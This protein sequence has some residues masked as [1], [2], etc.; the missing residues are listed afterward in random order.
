M[1]RRWWA[2]VS[3]VSPPRSRSTLIASTVTVTSSTSSTTAGFAAARRAVGT[4]L[5]EPSWVERGSDCVLHEL[6]E[7]FGNALGC[8]RC[9]LFLRDPTTTRNSMTHSWLRLPEFAYKRGINNSEW[10]EM[11]PTLLEDDPMFAEALRN[12][13]A[14]YIEDIE[15]APPELL[16]WE[17]EL[18][19]FGHRALIHAPIYLDGEMFGILEP[20]TFGTQTRKW[21]YEDRRLT[22]LVQ[23]KVGPIAADYVRRN[24]PGVGL[25]PA[26]KL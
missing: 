23:S 5:S 11:S 26:S 12:P 19:H 22:E 14:L 8:D 18:E 10:P 15:K 4:L 7:A 9:L 25:A 24:C 21:S 16:S 1:S 2:A 17:Y 3:S 6:M 13:L 20:C